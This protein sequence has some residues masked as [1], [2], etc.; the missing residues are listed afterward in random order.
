MTMN[1]NGS[2][3]SKSTFNNA[4]L[5]EGMEYSSE[6]DDGGYIEREP[7]VKIFDTQAE[8][9]QYYNN[10]LKESYGG[11]GPRIRKPNAEGYYETTIGRLRGKDVYSYDEI[12]NVRKW[13]LNN[14]H[15]YTYHPCYRNVEDKTTLIFCLTHY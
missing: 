11:R 10:K 8:A 7:T 2:L 5:I 6:D 15:H 9:K 1:R 3:Y 4:S 12:Y 13:G 14:T